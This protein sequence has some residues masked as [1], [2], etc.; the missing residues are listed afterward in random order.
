MSDHKDFFTVAGVVSAIDDGPSLATP[1]F[2]DRASN[3]YFIQNFETETS[4]DDFVYIGPEID[5]HRVDVPLEK[6]VHVGDPVEY[7]LILPG[8]K[9]MVL[10]LADLAGFFRKN[11]DLF[12]P[13]P[14]LFYQL[15]VLTKD[16][17]L[18]FTALELTPVRQAV[19]KR[20]VQVSFP[21]KREEDGIWTSDLER[22]LRYLWDANYS[23]SSIAK[24]VGLSRNAVIGKVHRL[25]LKTRVRGALD[26][27]KG[28]ADVAQLK[29]RDK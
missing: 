25:Q 3:G 14:F 6:K 13:H 5:G 19:S 20:E 18:I 24:L 1:I 7:G 17:D 27:R 10:T 26:A 29:L 9:H 21:R 15:A 22:L 2:R 12:L 23:A 8:G 11:H 16:R 28:P 4:V